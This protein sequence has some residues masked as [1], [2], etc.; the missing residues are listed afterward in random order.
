[1]PKK[2]INVSNFSG[3]INK[4]TNPRDMVANEYQEMLNLDN[5]VPG[6]LK[7]YGS[8]VTDSYNQ[9]NGTDITTINHGNGLHHFNLDRDIDAPTVISNREYLAINDPSNRRVR[10]IDYTSSSSAFDIVENITYATSGN[11]EV[12]MYN[13]DGALR[14]VP[15]VGTGGTP[16]ILYY[17]DEELHFG[18]DTAT[19]LVSE[20]QQYT[21]EDM[22]IA[23]LT[24]YITSSSKDLDP[25]KLY[26]RY[27][28]FKPT[29]QSEIFMNDAYS[30]ANIVDSSSG[31]LSTYN[32]GIDQNHGIFTSY[33]D[34]APT[35]GGVR[36]GF[37][38]MAYFNQY[39]SATTNDD[40]SDITIYPPTA[41]KRYGLWVSNIYEH[42]YESPAYHLGVIFQQSD[43]TTE[44]TRHLCWGMFGRAP[45]TNTRITGYKIYWGL[46]KNFSEPTSGVTY[47]GQV[48]A[49]YLFAEVDFHRG[50]RYAGEKT[51]AQFTQKLH[52][53][54]VSSSPDVYDNYYNWIYPESGYDNIDYFEGERVS[55]LSTVEPYI[56]DSKSII[57]PE[58]TGFNT[59]AIA[60]RRVYIGNVKYYNAEGDLVVKNDRIIKSRP[61]QFDYF[62]AESYIDVEVEDGDD[63]VK[64][65]TINQQLLEFKTRT[66]FIINVSRDIEYLEGSYPYKGCN[67]D[68]HVYEGEGF[69]T[70]FN[71]N[72]VYFYD[73]RQ[74]S[75]IH[76]NEN[77][78]S[79]FDDWKTNY[80]HDDN[81]IGFIPKTKEI[82]IARP[83]NTILKY[84][85]KSQSWTEG[86][87]FGSATY[88][89]T[90][91]VLK[92]D[93]ILTYFQDNGDST[94]TLKN[95]NPSSVAHTG[96]NKVLLKTKEF[97]FGNP[98]NN[99]NI[100]TIYVNYKNG[101]N[102][103]VQGF[104]TKRDAS[105]VGLTDISTLSDTSG[106]FLT[107]RIDLNGAFN[108]V[109]SFGIA[110]KLNGT[111]A[112]DFEINDIQIV[113]RDKVYR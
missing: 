86:D 91:F 104:A 21:V 111:S 66:L 41:G 95:W 103:T 73:G 39:A 54:L 94:I 45:G 31:N 55:S 69:V 89:F 85:L 62:E 13:I 92:N 71:N 65:S 46:I 100:N 77:G 36:G 16:K 68:Y 8:T 101:Q 22:F 14:V 75:D 106:G 99:K 15:K 10:V 44:V 88:G 9:T 29:R 113:Y 83:D 25:E 60:N 84:D 72:G 87:N 30:D 79:I 70:W 53:V 90:N 18:N 17:Q 102:I 2:I 7:L 3:G 78:Q 32:F 82:Y 64:L 74:L 37:H 24:G 98:T 34:Y 57:G 47:D 27:Q 81:V 50:V 4:N 51:Y 63:I 40:N 48:D 1:M 28:V 38:L 61:N 108:D 23:G 33:N 97:D 43:L 76:L 6:K 20:V 107:T 58:S 93:E 59:A 109:V 11:H 105:A 80:Y 5:E 56:G 67:K 112:S 26:K 19:E 52:Q 12:V 110:L 42:R 49:K 96:S 35:P